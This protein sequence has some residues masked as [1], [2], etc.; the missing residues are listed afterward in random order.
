MSAVE[1]IELIKKL[2]PEEWEEV[3]RFVVSQAASAGTSGADRDAQDRAQTL[4]R[5]YVVRHAELF[6]KL[7]Q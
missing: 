4:G 2:P 6:R 7:A 5:E 1:V 3:R